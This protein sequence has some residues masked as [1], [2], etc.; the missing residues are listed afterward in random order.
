MSRMIE[1]EQ[2]GELDKGRKSTEFVANKTT[3]GQGGALSTPETDNTQMSK[4]DHGE[5]DEGREPAAFVEIATTERQGVLST[6]ETAGTQILRMEQEPM[7]IDEKE[8]D[9]DGGDAVE[10]IEIGERGQ[11]A[12][13]ID[14][15]EMN[16]SG[17]KSLPK[18]DGDLKGKSLN[19]V[20]DDG[21]VTKYP[22]LSLGWTTDETGEQTDK[23]ETGVG[24]G[25]GQSND[26]TAGDDT[27]IANVVN[28]APVTE[29]TGQE[30]DG[31]MKIPVSY[32]S[33]SLIVVVAVEDSMDFGA[34]CK[35]TS[36]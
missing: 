33:G 16:G 23:T 10:M 34:P 21:S 6:P 19:N 12:V 28:G 31:A 14:G 22:V 25:V 8:A 27:K 24:N 11:E 1:V 32:E 13:S 9:G 5:F 18:V 3:E 15:N 7:G 4:M 2:Q 20:T 17:P 30:A 36:G 29:P 35:M 26:D